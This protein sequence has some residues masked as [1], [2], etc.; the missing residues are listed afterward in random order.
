MPNGRNP[1][2]TLTDAQVDDIADRL[3]R[4]RYE[5]ARPVQPEE[6]LRAGFLGS[7]TCRE[8]VIGR[9]G[10]RDRW[11]S[12]IDEGLSQ[13]GVTMRTNK[14]WER[15]CP[16]ITKLRNYGHDEAVWRIVDVRSY[17]TVCYSTGFPENARQWAFTLFGWTLPEGAS[18]GHLRA[19]LVS[20]GGFIVASSMNSELVGRLQGSLREAEIQIKRYTSKRDQLS[21]LIDSVTSANAHLVCGA[22]VE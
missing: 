6:V 21:S 11:S 3:L 19:E 16:H 18:L 4:G 20:G 8:Y 17:D 7:N 12:S 22:T 15:V 10:M 1:S 14:L 13:A 5:K 2:H 9:W